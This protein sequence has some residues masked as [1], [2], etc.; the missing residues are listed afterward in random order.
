MPRWEKRTDTVDS[1]SA[2]KSSYLNKVYLQIIV[3]LKWSTKKPLR[4]KVFSEVKITK[5]LVT[6][7][8]SLYGTFTPSSCQPCMFIKIIKETKN[9]TSSLWSLLDLALSGLPALSV[10]IY[11]AN[12][13]RWELYLYIIVINNPRKN[14]WLSET[15]CL[16]DSDFGSFTIVVPPFDNI[17]ALDLW[18][19]CQKTG[20]AT[21]EPKNRVLWYTPVCLHGGYL[22]L[23]RKLVSPDIQLIMELLLTQMAQRS[24]HSVGLW[25]MS[26]LEARSQFF[27]RQEGE[28]L[29]DIYSPLCRQR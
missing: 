24:K 23:E 4:W 9:S 26:L 6:E 12:D 28:S 13:W 15:D 1:K 3:V 14:S 27:H 18:K 29:L 10:K 11:K 5:Q 2:T 7:V 21:E 25:T 16:D 8:V 19:I 17:V 20:A 22:P